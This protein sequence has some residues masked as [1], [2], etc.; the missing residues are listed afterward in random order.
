MALSDDQ[1]YKLELTINGV[2]EAMDKP[3]TDVTE[4]EQGFISD[5]AERY[6]QYGTGMRISDKQW[7]IIDR[8]YDK[9]VS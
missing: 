9:V 1:V 2:K 7:A 3:D 5:Q 4:W 8:V 6:E